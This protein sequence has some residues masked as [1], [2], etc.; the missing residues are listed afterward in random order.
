[1]DSPIHPDLQPG[2][3]PPP[4]PLPFPIRNDPLI[5]G[6]DIELAPTRRPFQEHLTNPA[7]EVLGHSTL[8]LAAA[9]PRPPHPQPHPDLLPVHH[10]DHYHHHQQ[11]HLKTWESQSREPSLYSRSVSTPA[12]AAA[13][14]TAETAGQR[15][16]Y[17]DFSSPFDRRPLVP[18]SAA[19]GGRGK[20]E[21]ICGVRRHLFWI[22]LAVGVFLVVVGVA[23]G[24]GV[25]VGMLGRTEG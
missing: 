15:Y 14:T 16:S 17:S 7:P 8:E 3:R 18:G 9:K 1:M 13:S 4:N 10:P 20:R 19:G 22:G 25:G 23:T 2:P 6:H 12:S 11:Q 24:V 21:R 5:H